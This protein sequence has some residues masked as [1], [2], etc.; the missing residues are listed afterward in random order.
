MCGRVQALVYMRVQG[1]SP[2]RPP[3]KEGGSIWRT[4]NKRQIKKGSK[5]LY[6]PYFALNMVLI[7]SDVEN[8]PN[9]GSGKKNFESPPLHRGVRQ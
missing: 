6:T 8:L 9:L 4:T 5:P 2:D 3:Y 1:L 7:D